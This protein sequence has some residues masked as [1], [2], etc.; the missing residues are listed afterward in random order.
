MK[1]SGM[2]KIGI[3]TLPVTTNYGGIL[4]LYA[5]YMTLKNLGFSVCY[6]QRRWNSNSYSLI[7]KIK[8]FLYQ[9]IVIRRFNRFIA[10]FILS[11]TA[12]I[13]TQEKMEAIASDFST[14]IVGSDQ[15]WRIKN[16]KG[17]GLNYFL[18]FLSGEDTKRVAYAASFGVGHWEEVS[19]EI[20][21]KVEVL[22]KRFDAISVREKSGVEICQKIFNTNAIQ[23]LD[24]TLL[25]TSEDYIQNLSLRYEKSSVKRLG[26][27]LLDENHSKLYVIKE[28]AAKY[29]YEIIFL[30][31][32]SFWVGK[33]INED[34]I[35]RDVTSWLS[36]LY[37]SD[38]VITDSFHG[39]AF[40]I[41]FRKNFYTFCNDERGTT[42]MKSLLNL[43]HIPMNRLVNPAIE[44]KL[45]DSNIDFDVVESIWKYERKKSIFFLL[46]YI[47]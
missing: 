27:Y 4:Q 10:S 29:G 13:D 11:R 2:R 37:N 30:N 35:K 1:I 25:L 36:L 3:L 23:L 31:K 20:A 46:K 14:I 17:V 47:R 28:F 41:I 22:L 5:L 16:T 6:I 24:P 44:E 40:S 38:Y 45:M 15:V 21:K 42:R 33:H 26:V 8:R 7:H 9:K 18:D 19:D 12:I 43:F 34:L 39:T 32:A